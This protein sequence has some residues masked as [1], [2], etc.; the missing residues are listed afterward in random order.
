VAN[1]R[2]ALWPGIAIAVGLLGGVSTCGY[3]TLLRLGSGLGAIGCQSDG[4]NASI[5]KTSNTGIA[6]MMLGGIGG[7]GLIALVSR[8][9]DPARPHAE[10]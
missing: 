6:W 3:G 9:S 7:V 5:E 1:I 8:S 10:P 2:Q 4:C